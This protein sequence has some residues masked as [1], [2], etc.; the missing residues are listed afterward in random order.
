[1]DTVFN[2]LLHLFLGGSLLLF[3]AAMIA[4]VIREEDV[5]EKAIRAIALVG[6]A[7][8]ALAAEVSGVGYANFIVDALAGGG[9]TA[10]I[11]K[12]LAVV[13]P[14]GIG[15]VLAWYLVRVAKRDAPKGVR[16]LC[17]LGMLI[18]VGFI[19]IYAK[20]TE[21]RGVFIKAA[22]LPNAAFLV[23]TILMLVVQVDSLKTGPSD[24]AGG[25]R[26]F[27]ALAGELGFT[28]EHERRSRGSTSRNPYAD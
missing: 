2:V 20:A 27:R 16:L 3:T 8:T 6:G 14:G 1:M 26:G 23:G 15:A 9:P 12:L 4:I 11:V 10:A 19:E 5:G 25:P 7:I 18:A 24:G 13:I 17:F 28:R 21:T 22:A